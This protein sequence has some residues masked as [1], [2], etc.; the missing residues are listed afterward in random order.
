MV[1]SQNLRAR[2]WPWAGGN[3]AGNM[4]GSLRR[5]MLVPKSQG[6][7]QSSMPA[8]NLTPWH[9][10]EMGRWRMGAYKYGPAPIPQSKTC[11][12]GII[13]YMCYTT[14]CT[15]FYTTQRITHY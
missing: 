1:T 10:L 5:A 9:H 2:G 14:H 4:L 13:Q 12:G 6:T 7:W 3:I 11:H 15:M 8:K